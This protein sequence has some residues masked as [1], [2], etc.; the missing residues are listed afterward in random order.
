MFTVLLVVVV[1]IIHHTSEPYGTVGISKPAMRV[2][3]I[4]PGLF[5]ARRNLYIPV[6][7]G[8]VRLFRRNCDF[9]YN[10]IFVAALLLLGGIEPN[11][12][13]AARQPVVAKPSA[14]RIGSLNVRSARR[15][16]PLIHNVIVDH[17][18]DVLVVVETW[19]SVDMPPAIVDDIAPPG[20]SA[21]HFM[22]GSRGGGVS[23][24]Y[25]SSL[26][27]SALSTSISSATFESMGLKITSGTSVWNIFGIYR[28][29]PAPNAGFFDELRD[30]ISEVH[31]M[32]GLLLLCGDFNCPGDSSDTLDDRLLD[33]AD[34]FNI[35]ICSSTA[36]G[37]KSDGSPG[38]LLD[39]IMHNGTDVVSDFKTA[40]TGVA[41]HLLVMASLRFPKVNAK[42][43]SF[44]SRNLKRLD[45]DR[46]QGEL[47]KCSFI[48]NPSQDVDVFVDQLQ[49]D[50][51]SVLDRLAPIHTTTKRVGQNHESDLSDDAVKAKR[52]RRKCERRFRRSKN[53]ADRKAYRKATR[54]A[55]RMIIAS[56]QTGN[57]TRLNE[58]AGDQK[59]IWR[60]SNE[61]LHRKPRSCSIDPDR[62]AN[63]CIS[64]KT[65]FINKLLTIRKD[66]ASKLAA[67][68]IAPPLAIPHEVPFLRQF[69][70]VTSAEVIRIISSMKSKSSPL[71]TI[72]T[73]VLK[74]CVPVF[75]PSLAHM[76]NLSFQ[77]GIFPAKF[78]RGH[79]IPL[80]KKNDLDAQDPLNYRPITNLSTISKVLERLAMS[81]IKPFIHHSRNFGIYQSAYRQGHS[82]E[83]ALLRVANDLNVSMESK[84]C[85]VLLSLDISAAFDTINTVT[86]LERLRSDFGIEDS[87]SAWLRSYLVDRECYV[88]IGGCKSDLWRC[89]SGVPQGSVLGPL[90]FS[91][92]V[93]PISR[94]LDRFG[95]RY[96]QY[97][98]DTQL[99]TEIK[100]L[101][102]SQLRLLA[103][104]VSAL[105]HW[106][107]DNGLQ[108]N[109][110]KTEAMIVGTKPG[111]AKLGS[112]PTLRIGDGDVVTRDNIKILGVHLDPTL[113]MSENVKATTKACNFH[114]WALRH[115]RRHLT[116]E[117]TRTIAHGLV[118][119]RLD[120]CNALLYGTNKS[121]IA[122]LQRVQ[123]NLAR[124]VLQAAWRD[125]PG[126]LLER[127]HWLPVCARIDYKIALTTFKVR[128]TKQPT[129]LHDLLLE[130]IPA[131]S[132]RSGDQTL[133]RIPLMKSL[134]ACR[135][136]SYAA[137][138]IWNS[139]NI[140]TRQA[141]SLGCF[142]SRLK[143]ELFEPARY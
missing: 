12:G 59:S 138:T 63:L 15:K 76:A 35:S 69:E 29:P 81:R 36:T 14:V 62:Q 75:A 64:F 109:S 106:F 92:Y 107:L 6:I 111:L 52:Y 20:F 71:D 115:T 123:N 104:S 50:V 79:I 46:F 102:P 13:P 90:L 112:V 33:V 136:F 58:A 114:I 142:K 32:P 118:T 74:R 43:V 40:N 21:V 95:V 130:Y 25:R 91:A 49:D 101:D 4:L 135:S 143:T 30:F 28:P 129:Y 139:L 80:L 72:P 125:S 122:K 85:S 48:S 86:L 9:S 103:D 68:S 19:F 55:N 37:L 27:A 41:D 88:A 82:T 126:P 65:F 51:T 34:S 113:S 26:S 18:L 105:T 83:T 94:I 98:D 77:S 73:T 11:P 1:G 47:L 16:A 84:S 96:H 45:F 8:N 53:D 22:R 24:I 66:I 121:N 67:Y 54:V 132:L 70:P 93:S 131:R 10:I 61:I 140:A 23:V 3:R 7:V 127:L 56:A 124:V 17:S 133:L 134:S 5:F 97:A 89:D 57:Q 78:K 39:F 87:A 110:G 99:Y 38:N 60:I 119:S 100:S 108:L 31:L 141:A 117:A 116:L 128:Q 42:V 137:P 44:T 2:I 120:F